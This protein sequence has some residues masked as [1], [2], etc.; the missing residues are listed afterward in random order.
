MERDKCVVKWGV[1][2]QVMRTKEVILVLHVISIVIL[3]FVAYN[4]LLFTLI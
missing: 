4:H 1:L 2:N 3:K